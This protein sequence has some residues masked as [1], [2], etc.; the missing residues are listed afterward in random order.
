MVGSRFVPVKPKSESTNSKS[1]SKE[2][3]T[4]P[5]MEAALTAI[6]NKHASRNEMKAKRQSVRFED[7]PSC[8]S[9]IVKEPSLADT[10]YSGR[11]S[12]NSGYRHVAGRLSF[13]SIDLSDPKIRCSGRR[14]SVPDQNAALADMRHQ[15]SEP[16]HLKNNGGSRG[17]TIIHDSHNHRYGYSRYGE[18]LRGRQ[19]VRSLPTDRKF[20]YE[21]IQPPPEKVVH[22]RMS[23]PV[24]SSR[25]QERSCKSPSRSRSRSPSRS[26]TGSYARDRGFSPTMNPR[27]RRA[28][29]AR[30]VTEHSP[31]RSSSKP[32]PTPWIG[33]P[34]KENAND[35]LEPKSFKPEWWERK[36]WWDA[37]PE[38]FSYDKL[39]NTEEPS[40]ASAGLKKDVGPPVALK[41]RFSV[42]SFVKPP[43][44]GNLEVRNTFVPLRASS[45][46]QTPGSSNGYSSSRA[47]TFVNE[48]K[49]PYVPVDG[50]WG[51]Q[52]TVDEV[53]T[54][55]G[56]KAD[57]SDQLSPPLA[58][59]FEKLRSRRDRAAS[60]TTPHASEPHFPPLPS[61]EPLIPLRAS[62][63]KVQ[64]VPEKLERQ[65]NGVLPSSTAMAT[66]SRLGSKEPSTL[67]AQ[68]TSTQ[69]SSESSGEFFSRMTGRPNSPPTLPLP[70]KSSV[71]RASPLPY[72]NPAIRRSATVSEATGR[73]NSTTLRRPYSQVFDGKGR[74]EWNNFLRDPRPAPTPGPPSIP[75]KANAPGQG[76]QVFVLSPNR[77]EPP[78]PIEEYNARPG[79][80]CDLRHIT[81]NPA[82]N[83]PA[84]V[85]QPKRSAARFDEESAPPAHDNAET[86]GKIQEC[87]D[88]LRYLGY[89]SSADGGNTR[90]VVYAQAADGEVG[91]AVDLIEEERR[92]WGERRF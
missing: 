5:D 23:M 25:Q 40:R 29:S 43:P 84:T 15:Q 1:E 63:N 69:K 62:D 36:P 78:V 41:K 44:P 76:R 27:L 38:R 77:G 3:S 49:P 73:P 58:E 52:A 91:E 70:H 30:F 60:D 87:V 24:V 67:W 74:I 32:V 4:K 28:R 8:S 50:N 18:P 54:T 79:N 90:L 92:A 19:S 80:F 88:K 17:S 33:V 26:P 66:P 20:P 68:A 45:L 53:E 51:T 22:K 81:W 2:P 72:Y 64:P 75:P 46:K 9:D 59:Y 85:P 61:M 55:G 47:W 37:S 48:K 12:L 89:G 31:L 10:P 13:D 42:P 65:S 35:R 16:L 82:R 14:I 56:A 71:S 83:Q 34:S 7:P 21:Y 86:A 39:P 11:E 57:K 6:R